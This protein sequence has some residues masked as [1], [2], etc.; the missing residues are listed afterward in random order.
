MLINFKKKNAI[1]NPFKYN[2]VHYNWGYQI[3]LALV[4]LFVSCKTHKNTFVIN[5]FDVG[6][7]YGNIYPKI[8]N[9]GSFNISVQ[10]LDTITS[11]IKSNQTFNAYSPLDNP[12]Q[13]LVS[14]NR[15]SVVLS[16]NKKSFI[17]GN[18]DGRDSLCENACKLSVLPTDKITFKS[19]LNPLP[20]WHGFRG[21]GGLSLFMHYHHY[22]LKH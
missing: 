1:N 22:I 6:F 8:S 19:Y 13:V 5:R 3:C 11:N 10:T 4:F 17:L 14:K 9:V 16:S 12:V 15:T 21:L 2:Q 7:S 18:L 20:Y